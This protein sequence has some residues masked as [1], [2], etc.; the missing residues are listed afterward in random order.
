MADELLFDLTPKDDNKLVAA[1]NVV[2]DVL[3]KIAAKGLEAAKAI[4]SLFASGPKKPSTAALGEAAG[5]GGGGGSAL[6]GIAE[7]AMTAFTGVAG[8]LEKVTASAVSYAA[9]FSPATVDRYNLAQL[10]LQATI[11]EKLLPIVHAATEEVNHFADVIGGMDFADFVQGLVEVFQP[12]VRI[13]TDIVAVVGQLASVLSKHLAPTMKEVGAVLKKVSDEIKNLFGESIAGQRA[14]GVRGISLGSVEG[15]SDR[16]LVAA[17]RIGQ[18]SDPAERTAQNTSGILNEIRNNNAAV[19][20][21]A[22]QQVAS[23]SMY[24]QTE[25]WLNTLNRTPFLSFNAWRWFQ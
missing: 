15:I 12:L 2:Y 4:G 17:G 18:S 19:R 1:L 13:F 22:Q 6:A 7:G 21:Q 16:A 5:G 3:S 24:E 8:V 14:T 25:G 20:G 23:R 9:A 10:D 11:G